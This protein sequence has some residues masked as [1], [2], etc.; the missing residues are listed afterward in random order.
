MKLTFFP[1]HCML[2]TLR[3]FVSNLML[4]YGTVDMKRK[5]AESKGIDVT[6]TQH[7]D[8]RPL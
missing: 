7:I 3:V 2:V 4:H 6:Q 8:F 1:K 5:N